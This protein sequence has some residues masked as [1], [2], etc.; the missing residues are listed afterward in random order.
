MWHRSGAWA[1]GTCQLHARRRL[2]PAREGRRGGVRPL[3]LL[4]Q[5]R[6][7]PVAIQQDPGYPVEGG[8]LAPPD[9]PRR[10]SV[11][12]ALRQMCC[13]CPETGPFRSL[14]VSTRLPP[15]GQRALARHRTGRR[16]RARQTSRHSVPRSYG[17]ALGRSGADYS[18]LH[19]HIACDAS[20]GR[21]RPDPIQG[22]YRRGALYSFLLLRDMRIESRGEARR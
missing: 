13:R 22:E 5:D 8:V 20:R 19:P 18:L 9:G 7:L 1:P 11:T 6:A 2:R 21:G 12:H 15:Q 16:S 3:L 14:L 10:A 4:L 17:P